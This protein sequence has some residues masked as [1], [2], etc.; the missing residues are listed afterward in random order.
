M[1]Y[2]TATLSIAMFRRFAACQGRQ[3]L[4][5]GAIIGAGWGRM[6]INIFDHTFPFGLDLSQ[7]QSFK[8]PH[9]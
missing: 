5:S 7:L 8:R 3:P 2:S 9:H 4:N 6:G 1:A